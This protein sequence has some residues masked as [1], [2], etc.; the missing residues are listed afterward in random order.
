M[1]PFLKFHFKNSM[2]SAHRGNFYK[3]FAKKEEQCVTTEPCN[4]MNV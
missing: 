4:E 3:E 1:L 2:G